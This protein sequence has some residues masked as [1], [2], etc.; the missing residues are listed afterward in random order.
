MKIFAEDLLV[1]EGCCA[2][3]VE[4]NGNDWFDAENSL[5]FYE[6]FDDVWGI[7]LMWDIG[8]RVIFRQIIKYSIKND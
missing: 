2:K 6:M 8:Y 3:F 1:S 4:I 7:G 5:I